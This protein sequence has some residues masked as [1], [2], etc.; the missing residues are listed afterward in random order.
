[1]YI[2]VRVQEFVQLPPNTLT[3]SNMTRLVGLRIV[4]MISLCQHHVDFIFSLVTFQGR[5]RI[6]WQCD[7]Y[8]NYMKK[9]YMACLLV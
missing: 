8:T 4:E 2:K 6:S 3:K 7:S 5:S 9:S 1:M